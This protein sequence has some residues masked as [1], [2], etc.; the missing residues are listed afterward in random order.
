ME[1]KLTP[2]QV[3]AWDCAFSRSLD[4]RGDRNRSISVVGVI[5]LEVDSKRNERIYARENDV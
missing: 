4:H 3:L 5:P 1:P 2:T